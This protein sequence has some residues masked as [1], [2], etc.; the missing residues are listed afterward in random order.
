MAQASAR[1]NPGKKTDQMENILVKL[2]DDGR[3]NQ[4]LYAQSVL[5]SFKAEQSKNRKEYSLALQYAEECLLIYKRNEVA[6]NELF[7]YNLIIDIYTQ[8]GDKVK[9]EE[10]TY[11]KTYL[12]E[13]KGITVPIFTLT[14]FIN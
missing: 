4:T 3:I 8:L 9:I 11:K 2:Y 1:I 10:Y 7:I 5:L 12:L 14:S 13:R 6:L